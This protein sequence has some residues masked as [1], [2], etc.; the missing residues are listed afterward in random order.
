MFVVAKE[1]GEITGWMNG[2][3]P[4]NERS[5]TKF[6][7]TE[8]AI[9]DWDGDATGLDS[10]QTITLP[11]EVRRMSMSF[12]EDALHSYNLEPRQSGLG[13]ERALKHVAMQAFSRKGP[14]EAALIL[15]PDMQIDLSQ[16]MAAGP[17]S[18]RVD[19]RVRVIEATPEQ[20]E[21]LFDCDEAY[22][23]I[24][25][26]DTGTEEIDAIIKGKPYGAMLSQSAQIA[27][28]A[29]TASSLGTSISGGVQPLT[30]MAGL[31]VRRPHATAM[32][33][34]IC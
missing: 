28:G 14:I 27:A 9:W 29:I 34:N 20:R 24:S 10:M 26:W 30:W 25:E 23:P 18:Y 11:I 6:T 22:V 31:T 16:D 17:W 33:T 15:D 12:A 5:L 21:Q 4:A 2:R 8:S 19:S 32:I 3:V 7:M 13:F 1:S